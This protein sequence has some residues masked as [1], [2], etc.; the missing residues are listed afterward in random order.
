MR[1]GQETG[2]L[3]KMKKISK[4]KNRSHR[5]RRQKETLK[6]NVTEAKN[7]EAPSS[8]LLLRQLEGSE[9]CAAAASK[10]AAGNAAA[11]TSRAGGCRN[12][13]CCYFKAATRTRGRRGKI[14]SF[15]SAVHIGKNQGER[16]THTAEWTKG[17]LKPIPASNRS[18]PEL[19]QSRH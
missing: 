2:Q 15:I 18:S 16:K 1:T 19:N 7:H 17:K 12:Y 4:R 14:H 6:L 5:N 13:C 9:G 3:R 8:V 11:T 10:V